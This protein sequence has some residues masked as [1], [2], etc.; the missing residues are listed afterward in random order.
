MI[1]SKFIKAKGE[2]EN[3]D[4]IHEL[5]L[6]LVHRL[7]CSSTTLSSTVLGGVSGVVSP[8]KVIKVS[9]SSSHWISCK[10]S[11]KSSSNT[12]ASKEILTLAM[13]GLVN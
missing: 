7:C 11:L 9:C 4:Q 8:F 1:P 6:P 13:R 10:V 3:L 12:M 2:R 5:V